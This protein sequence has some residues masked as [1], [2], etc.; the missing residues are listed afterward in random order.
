MRT[1][2]A[3]LLVSLT[4]IVL[5]LVA[6]VLFVRARS[7]AA[8]GP[9]VAVCPGPDHYGYTC[10]DGN[11]YSYIDATTRLGLYAD[12]AVARVDLPF[13]FTFYGNEYT[14]VSVATN[15]H[16]QFGGES[17]T[18]L[19]SCLS[20]AANGGD[21]IAPYWS[22]LDLTLA[23]ELETRVFGEAPQRLF[24]IEWDETPFYGADPAQSVTF[25]VQLFEGS[26]DIVFLYEDPT[27]S[28][29]S[30]GRSAVTGIQSE[31]QGLA[32]SFS[33]FQPVLPPAGGLRF[34]HPVQA[35]R[36]PVR[37]EEAAQ[38]TAPQSGQTGAK[39]PVGRL[40]EQYGIDGAEALPR[41]RACWLGERPQRSFD[42]RVAGV[43]GAEPARELIAVWRGGPEAPQMAEVA[44]LATRDDGLALLFHAH[45]STREERYAE[46]IIEDVTDLTGDGAADVILRD[47]P[48][49]QV[50]VLSNASGQ[51]ALHEL[52]ERCRGGLIAADTDGNG[53][54]ELIRDG[55]TTAG[56]VGA[57]WDGN[58]FALV[59]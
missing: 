58:G 11:A 37:P 49:G 16:L 25:E 50:W 26:N 1:R 30:N 36:E 8:Y 43:T 15:G 48:T 45:L 27:D 7:G 52:P 6:F 20:P 42:W 21:L 56:R 59:P 51:L 28:L 41:L 39:G 23:G 53:Q 17:P 19:P 44:V 2:P 40:I 3:L 22:D 38:G 35:N 12:D 29:G 9:A 4:A 14:E 5:V 54:I 13:E 18:A 55:C 10:E 33:C 57:I 47:R 46:I 31:S 34:V 24:V 32:L